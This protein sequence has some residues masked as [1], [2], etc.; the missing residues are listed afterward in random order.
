MISRTKFSTLLCLIVTVA[1]LLAS[2]KTETIIETVEV[3]VEVE[4]PK[5]VEV[6]ITPTPEPLPQ[7]G[8]VVLANYADA[9]TLNPILASD[10]A[11]YAVWSQLFLTLLTQDPFT[12]EIVGQIA[13]S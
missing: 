2:C 7:G 4:K 12:G 13:E 3:P 8:R 1:I 11:S 10:F 5:E 6:F 9:V